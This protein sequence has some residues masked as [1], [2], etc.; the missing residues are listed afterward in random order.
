MLSLVGKRRRAALNTIAVLSM[1]LG[2]TNYL[3]WQTGKF[4]RVM[5]LVQKAAFVS[6]F[7]WIVVA[8]LAIRRA[9]ATDAAPDANRRLT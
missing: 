8:T 3:M 5:P 2:V 7:I 1:I 4:L 9:L 6:F